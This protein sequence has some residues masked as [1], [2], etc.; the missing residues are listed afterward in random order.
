[1]AGRTRQT[2]SSL[3]AL[4][5]LRFVTVS[6]NDARDGCPRGTGPRRPSA[7]VPLAIA[8]LECQDCP[9]HS[10]YLRV[11]H[12]V[13]GA[14]LV[15]MMGLRP[16]GRGGSQVDHSRRRG[17]VTRQLPY[18]EPDG[19]GVHDMRARNKQATR[20]AISVAALRLAVEQGPTG[21][22]LV[23]VADIATAAGI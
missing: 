11:T 13:R 23:R 21:L 16:P 6:R 8:W 3:K 9:Y 2:R 7:P 10:R 17:R 15:A 20:E 19:N 4:L 12:I 22:K 18:P 14:H 5:L 1:R